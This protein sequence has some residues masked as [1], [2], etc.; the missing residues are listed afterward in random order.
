MRIPLPP[1]PADAFTTTGYLIFLAILRASSILE[2]VP[3]LPGTIGT[4]AF[5]IAFLALLLSPIFKIT[6][7]DGPIK[8]ILQDSQTSAK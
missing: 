7:L 1:P 8:V 6:S 4:P 3:L 2:I 5:S